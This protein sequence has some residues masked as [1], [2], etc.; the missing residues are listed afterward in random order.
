MI[1]GERADLLRLGPHQFPPVGLDRAP[2]KTG[3]Q[4]ELCRF[5]TKCLVNAETGKVGASEKALSR[6]RATI[7]LSLQRLCNL[8][9]AYLSCIFA[10]ERIRVSPNHLWLSK[11]LRHRSTCTN[12]VFW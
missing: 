5:L 11:R 1:Q 10:Q 7:P 6:L 4:T 12:G 3:G 9:I 8:W 2:V